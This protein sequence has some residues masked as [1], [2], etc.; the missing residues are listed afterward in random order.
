MDWAWFPVQEDRKAAQNGGRL[1]TLI[2]VL[3]LEAVTRYHLSSLA[4]KSGSHAELDLHTL[5]LSA[6]E[7]ALELGEAEGYVR[8]FIDEGDVMQRLLIATGRQ[9]AREWTLRQRA[10][11][12]RLL[13]AFPANPPAHDVAPSAARPAAGLIEPL[14]ERELEI[15]RMITAGMN[16]Q[17]IARKLIIAPG[18]VKA[19]IASLYRKLDVHS[20]TE[21]VAAA[22]ALGLLS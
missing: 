2:E 21:A 7:Q 6:L 11:L 17:A 12:A 13:Q 18:T 9:P 1:N 20:R 14:S 3:A 15:L 5:A 19:H 10:Y 4:A 16:T 8:V 22:R